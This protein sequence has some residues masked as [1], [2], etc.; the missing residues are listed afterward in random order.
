MVCKPQMD[1]SGVFMI[2]VFDTALHNLSDENQPITI[3]LLCMFSDPSR[4]ESQ[5]FAAL[6][7]TLTLERRRQVINKMVE[8]YEERF[9]LDYGALF[10]ICLDDAD[11]EVRRSA[12]DG[13]WEDE[14]LDL[15]NTFIRMM[16]TDPDT[17]VRAA[18]ASSLASFVY[19]AECDELEPTRTVRVRL[20]LEQTINNPEEDLEVVRRAVEAISFI[21][22]DRIRAIIEN[23]YSQRDERM[24]VSA[25][26]AIGRNADPYWADIIITE[27]GNALAIMRFEAVRASGEL[28]LKR[29]VPLLVG[30]VQDTDPEVQSV[31]V[32]ALGQVGGKEAEATLQQLSTS[33]DEALN[34]AALEALNELGFAT[35]VMDMIVHDAETDLEDLIEVDLYKGN[36]DGDSDETSAD[37]WDDDP[38]E[39]N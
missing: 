38:I 35:G 30:L 22:D 9:D 34:D 37:T 31:A 10:R 7:P 26:F 28:Q 21:N 4:N 24:R 17:L 39:L 23:A 16:Q 13:L 36:L 27:L 25:L 2:S 15:V 6:W 18:A 20:A 14:G 32:W 11:A 29:A 8:Q 1:Q 19:M 3:G 12:I 33:K 5:S